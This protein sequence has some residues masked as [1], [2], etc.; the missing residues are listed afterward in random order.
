MRNIRT[1]KKEKTPRLV[2]EKGRGIDEERSFKVKE[3]LQVAIEKI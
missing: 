2:V 1:L 3:P